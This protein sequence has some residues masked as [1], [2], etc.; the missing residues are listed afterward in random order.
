MFQQQSSVVGQLVHQWQW[1]INGGRWQRRTGS[2]SGWSLSSLAHLSFVTSPL[3]YSRPL[4]STTLGG[5][6]SVYFLFILPRVW[7][8]LYTLWWAPSTDKRIKASF[9]VGKSGTLAAELAIQT[10]HRD[11][12][13]SW[14]QYMR[15]YYHLLSLLC[16]NLTL[17][18][19]PEVVFTWKMPSFMLWL[20]EIGILIN[21]TSRP[22][23]TSF[24]N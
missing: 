11:C 12:I 18:M 16:L 5:T 2:F 22:L 9:C 15:F 3:R 8:P 23:C 21:N 10:K 14:M 7:I 17:E 24:V 1:F 4:K 6:S 19:Q 20:C 13:R